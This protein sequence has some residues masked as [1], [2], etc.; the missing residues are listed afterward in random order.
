[1]VSELVQ[2]K[3]PL[4][5]EKISKLI[6]K[7]AIPSIVAM[8]ISSLYNIVD[9]IF[10]G[11]GVGMLGNAATNVSFPLTTICIAIAL[12]VG[13]GS[14]T[15][16]SISLGKKDSNE[17]SKVVGN[18]L[19]MMIVLGALYCLLG[20]IF[21]SPLLNAF[22]ATKEN[23]PYAYIYSRIAL[24]G[25]PF[26]II[27]NAL[28]N[29][30]RAD[31][32]PKYSM[33]S[34]VVGAIINTILDP[35]FIFAFDMGV[36]GAAYATVI[37]QV[38]SCFI[39][40]LYIRNFKRVKLTKESF[41][42]DL[43]RCLN[44][45]LLGASN[46]LNQA[47]ICIVQIVM[48]NSLTHYGLLSIYG[49]DI[50]LA[51]FGIVMKVNS[52]FISFFVGVNQGTQPILGYNY[53]AK[54]YDR[55]KETYKKSLILNVIV[56][57]ISLLTFQLFPKAIISIFGNGQET[58]LYFE[59]AIKAMRIFLS[60]IIAVGIQFVSSNFFASIG[61]PIKGVAL[62]FSRQILFVIPLILILPLFMGIDGILFAGPISDLLACIIAI[63]FIVY[64]FK[65]MK[66]EENKMVSKISPIE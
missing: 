13:V 31:G 14:A 47:A 7:F 60:M 48:N 33:L 1:M 58:D 26:L 10:I 8:I 66:K 9:Q 22:G 57:T 29:L 35:I 16:F 56:A 28:S 5:Y 15:K 11:K 51:S 61:Q 54:Q 20:Q 34:M 6:K 37:S 24:F 3:N 38:V 21:I 49:E 53:G 18:A 50:P 41:K 36:A 19:W 4:G 45:S 44:I 27:N 2:E 40:I 32:S 64:Q 30:I 65:K 39:S 17:A 55:V 25:M 23:F 42:L 62:S 43:K 12:L 46:F 63:I 59:F 52:I